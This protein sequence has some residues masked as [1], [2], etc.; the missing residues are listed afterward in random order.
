MNSIE[1]IGSSIANH[2]STLFAQQL[3]G[4][5]PRYTVELNTDVNRQ[6]FGDLSCNGSLVI[7]KELKK[8]PRAVAQ[9]IITG[10]NHPLIERIE[11]AGPGFINIYLTQEA[12]KS[13][14]RELAAQKDIFFKLN[15]HEVPKRYNIEFVSANPTGPLHIG[16]GRGGIIG[17]VLGNILKFIGHSVVK[18][19][20]IND[21]GSQ[22]N[23]LGASFK[24]RCQ[25]KVGIAAEIPEGG[26][27]GEYLKVL[28]HTLI[29]EKGDAVLEQ[30]ATFFENYAKEHLLQ[31]LKDTLQEYGIRFDVWFS[32]K[33]LHTSGAIEQ[34]LAL[35][36]K[37]GFIYE[38]DNA[39]WFRSTD[40]GDDKDRV[41]KK[42]SGELTYVAA[43]VAYLQNKIDR[44]FDKIIMILG[45]DHHS[46]LV[47]L[48]AVIQALGYPAEMLD[49]ILYQLVTLKESGEL[50]KMSKRAG[51]IAGL[52][53]LIET[54]GTDVARFFYLNR[55]A[56]AHL[57]FDLDLALKHSDENPVFYIQ[58]AYVRTMSMLEKAE[59]IAELKNIT[60]D[61]AQ[62]V[63]EQEKL[64]LK[65]I[66][67]LKQLLADIS[68]H[69]QTHVLTY[70]V[71]ELAHVFHAYYGACRVIDKEQIEITRARL[72]VVQQLRDTFKLCMTLL[73]ITT[74]EKM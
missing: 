22:I 14:T 31:A 42:Q 66:V 57:D 11:I 60:I 30:P 41:L 29:T 56:D 18:E 46:Y 71:L 25:Q 35:L 19:F 23:K 13:L 44:H 61:D 32:E 51:R 63:T 67:A 36:E 68:N 52:R 1:Q 37:R 74:P 17:D 73:G 69:Y 34:A 5:M 49:I 65:K 4:D 53:D 21:A 26:Y 48:K 2:I 59:Q 6:Q 7:A 40:F 58:Y 16:H 27:Q 10:F 28:A 39:L 8:N 55:K 3:G 62:F 33:S 38:A 72:L 47:R 45:Q 24:A 43:D 12:F 9:E 54:V 64:L 20:Y 15:A 70:Y 50:V